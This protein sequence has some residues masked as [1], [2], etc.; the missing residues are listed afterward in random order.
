MDPTQDGCSETS[1][2]SRTRKISRTGVPKVGGVE[3]VLA[4]KLRLGILIPCVDPS[5]PGWHEEAVDR[6][7]GAPVGFV[8]CPESI[9]PCC[10]GPDHK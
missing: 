4:I 5:Q 8:H 6:L 3:T 1:S 10:F 9:G 7:S 2:S